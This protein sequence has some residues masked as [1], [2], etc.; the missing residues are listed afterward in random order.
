MEII[1][2]ESNTTPQLKITF[3]SFEENDC[4]KV[5]FPKIFIGKI[6]LNPF[7]LPFAGGKSSS[8]KNL[9]IYEIPKPILH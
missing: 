7:D 2:Q 3:I 5:L 9:C 8:T 4:A 6:G 1:Q